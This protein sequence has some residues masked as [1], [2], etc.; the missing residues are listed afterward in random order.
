MATLQRP[1]YTAIALTGL[2]SKPFKRFNRPAG[3][4]AVAVI[5]LRSV[6]S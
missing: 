5:S 1:G 3:R 6:L 2:N 4:V